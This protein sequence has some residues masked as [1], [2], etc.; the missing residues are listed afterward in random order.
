MLQ[1][2]SIFAKSLLFGA[3]VL[4]GVGAFWGAW[5]FENARSAEF[6]RQEEESLKGEINRVLPIGAEWVRV[7]EF[8]KSRS[9]LVGGHYRL[10]E[11][12]RRSYGDVAEILI[13]SSTDL[14]TSLYVCRIMVTFRFD[15][16]R[17]LQGY[18]TKLVC[19]GPFG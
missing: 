5:R 11:D 3:A 10:S 8:V 4:V 6:L 7:E 17:T 15:T 16:N 12:D 9:M 1:M 14:E 18:E 19:D 2:K 13:A